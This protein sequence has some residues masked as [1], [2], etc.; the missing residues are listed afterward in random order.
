VERATALVAAALAA[1]GELGDVTA[2]VLDALGHSV[3]GVPQLAIF[4]GA[5]AAHLA[6]L[7]QQG[8]A[9]LAAEGGRLIWSQA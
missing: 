4:G 1:P 6:Y 2:R 9:R 7:E 3:G 5:V 8:R